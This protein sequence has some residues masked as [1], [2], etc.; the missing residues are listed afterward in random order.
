MITSPRPCRLV[1]SAG[2]AALLSGSVIGI[3][4]AD[5]QVVKANNTDNLNVGTSWIG[6]SVP[7]PA[8]IAAWDATVTGANSTLLGSDLTWGGITITN[9]GGLITI[10]GANRLTVA[11]AIGINLS[12]STQDLIIN[13]ALTVSGGTTL[14][15]RVLTLSGPN[16]VLTGIV[17][18]TATAG[19][20]ALNVTGGSLLL[21]GA[22][23]FSGQMGIGS[24]ATVTARNGS[25]L[26]A[27]GVGN[28]TV[29]LAGGTLNIGGQALGVERIRISGTGVGGV[30]AL[31][32][33]GAGNN[34]ATQF[35]S[36]IGNATVNAGGTLPAS[37]NASGG[38]LAG[39]VGR[40]DIRLASYT[41]NAANLNLAG[42]T[43]TKIGGGQFSLV[44][45][46]VTAGNIVV[47]E[48]VL[49][50]E[51]TT[52][53]NGAGTI[54]VNQGGKLAF[55]NL[56]NNGA[57]V[58]WPITVN[59]G[60][61][62]DVLSVTAAQTVAAPITIAGP[63]N[64]NFVAASGSLTTM[65]GVISKNA[66]S[67]ATEL[68]KRGAQV[69]AFSNTGNTFDL[70]VAIYQGTL[71]AIY[72][73]DLGAGG[74]PPNAAL[75]SSDNPLGTNPTIKLAGG[76]LS[77][78]I[79]MAN[80]ATLQ[81]WDLN[82]A[83]VIDLAPSGMDFD[84]RTNTAQTNKHV[85]ID[86][87]TFSPPNAANGY[88][89]GQNQFTFT[90]LNT[91]RLEIAQMT[92]ARDTHLVGGDQ[93]F[94][95]DILSPGKNSLTRSGGSTTQFIIPA[96]HEFNAYF[97][98]GGSTRVGSGFG[99]NTTDPNVKIGTGLITIGPGA[100]ITFLSSTNI[101]A[102]QPITLVSHRGS[103]A[104][105]NFEQFT[106]VPANLRA[107]GTG[108]LGLGGTAAFGDLDLS[109]LGDGTFRAGAGISGSGATGVINGQIGAGAGN[110]VRLGASG[111]LNVS[112]SNLITGDAVLEVGSPL[113][114]GTF[115]QQ[116]QGSQNG[117]VFLTETNNYTGGTIVNRSSTIR[118]QDNGAF[119][120]GPITAFGNLTAEGDFGT[121]INDAGTGHIPVSFYG[122]Y[123]VRF[124]SSLTST[125]V[126]VDRWLD[127]VPIPLLNATLQLDAR[128]SASTT[129][130]TV[131]AI[132]YAGGSTISL[133]RS[134]TPGAA[135]VVQLQTPSITRV[136]NGT[137]EITRSGNSGFGSTVRLLASTTAPTLTNN[138][139]NPS[140]ALIDATRLTTFATYDPSNGFLNAAYTNTVTTAG[141]PTGLTAG[142]EIVYVDFATGVLTSTLGDNPVVYALKVGAGQSAATAT[143][144]AAG[145]GTGITIRSGG[146]IISGDAST[147]N[148]S[149]AS[150]TQATINPSL[151]FNN[152]TSNI[153]ALINVRSATTGI[154]NGQIVANGLTKF[155]AG[156]L[157][158]TSNQPS[159]SGN[160]AI[161]QGIIQAFGSQTTG[162]TQN[163]LG[164]GLI[165]LTGG[166]LNL[167]TANFA[168]TTF[169][170]SNNGSYTM[171]N[172]FVIPENIP[173]GVVDVNRSTADTTSTGTITF[174]PT[175]PGSGLQLLGSAGAQ[176]QTITFSGANYGVV[177]DTNSLNSFA[178]NVTVNNAVNVTLQNN[179]TITGTNPVIT[180]S[181][182]GVLVVGTAISQPLEVTVVPGA[183]VVVNAGTLEMRNNLAFGSGGSTGTSLV[184]NGGALNLRSNFATTYGGDA[185]TPYAVT[186]NGN[187]TISTDRSDTAGA[188]NSA[189]ELDTL[190]IN[191]SPTVTFNNANGVYPSILGS[192]D[193]VSMRLNGLPFL[194]SNI[195]VGNL[196]SALRL[197]SA[198]VGGGFVKLGTGH[199]HLMDSNN[200]SGGTYIN[201]GVLRA[202]ATN[203]LGV[204]PVYLNPGAILDLNAI[205]N[206]RPDQPLMI[207]SNGA[208]IPML[209]V[210]T[211]FAHPTGPNV[212][213]SQA[214]NGIVGLSNG[215]GGIYSTVINLATMYG[216]QWSL[217]GVPSGVYDPIY[218]GETLGAGLDGLYRLGGGGTSFA[219]G[220]DEFRGAR[221]NVLTGPNN[222]RLGFDSGNLYP[223]NTTNFQFSIAG[224]NDYSGGSTV[225][226]RGMVARLFS[227]NDGA[228][229]G[230]SNSN[231]DV[232][233]IFGLSGSG[234]I[235]TGLANTNTVTL[236]PGSGLVLDSANG[237]ANSQ[238]SFAASNPGDRWNDTTPIA[239]NGAFLD[240]NGQRDA[241][242]T[243]IVGDVTYSRGARVR[244]GRSPV[245]VNNPGGGSSI[246]TMAN[247]FGTGPGNTL[248]LQTTLPGTLGG[249]DQILVTNNPPVVTNG[250]VSSSV[251]NVTDNTFVTYDVLNGFT[252]A[253]YDSI[254]PGGNIPTG[255]SA[256]TKLDLTTAAATLTDS[257]TVYALRTSQ[258]INIGGA[259]STINLRSGGL[260][261]T[262]GT[263][264]PNLVFND[265]AS[266][267]EGRIYVNG[268]LT[269]NGLI[270]ANG[271]TKFGHTGTAGG[272]AGTLVIN[273]P[274]PNYTSG[275]TVNSGALQIN[276]PQGLGQT[277][278]TNTITLN[279]SLSTTGQVNS[280][281]GG[282]NYAPTQLTLTYNSGTP[283]QVSFS[284]GPVTVVNE[285]TVRIAAG[286]DRNLQGLPVTLTSTSPASRVGFTMDVPNN[287]FRGTIPSLT[288]MNDAVIRVTDS[289]STA[290]TGR[291][292]AGVVT[293]LNG[294]GKNLTKIGNR[295]LELP[296][297][298][299]TTF[300]GGSVTVSQGTVRV[301]NN[302]SLG[303]P[304]TVTTIERNATLEIDTDAFTSAGPVNQ[305]PGSIERWN[306]EAARP[307]TTYNFPSGVNLQLNTN[308]LA[309][310]T[311]GLNGGSIEGFNWIDHPSAAVLRTVSSNV[312][313]N[314]LAD[315]FVG[316]NILQGQGYDAGRQPTVNSPFGEAVTGSFLQI[317]G[318][319]TGNFNL[320]KTGNDTVTI[321][322]ANT[323][324]NTFVEL[325]VLRTGSQNTLPS[326]GVVTTRLNGTLDLFGNN[327]TVS[328]LG[329]SATGA[330][331]GGTSVGSSGR[332]IN[333]APTDNILNVNTA[334]NFTYNGQ[335]EQNVALTKSGTGIL[336]LNAASG[337][338][339][340]TTV[341][342]GTLVVNAAL[343]GTSTIDVRSGAILDVSDVSSGFQLGSKQL[344]KGDGTIK[345]S[346]ATSGTVTPGSVG[347][348]ALTIDALTTLNTGSTL[349]LELNA[350]DT[351]DR[352]VTN[353]LIL[354][355]IVNLA[356]NLN[357]TPAVATQF[358]VVDNTGLNAVGGTTKLFTW[359]GPEGVLSEGEEFFVGA[360]LFSITYQGG[361][362]NDVV[363]VVVPEPSSLA[364]IAGAMGL[365]A[366]RRRRS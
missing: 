204:G 279:A 12:G 207:R 158:I 71:R 11:G 22:N 327:Q 65:S 231:V 101:G 178:G 247:L 121:F 359:N 349:Q 94:T 117:T 318:N 33:E 63:L 229:S 31:I 62:G 309:A 306:R 350:A 217:G 147:G 182:G 92:M 324:R 336:Q 69:L 85:I 230:F 59:G 172:S 260:I 363:L 366:L 319:I 97:G 216:G 18:G 273:V 44:A 274:Q 137:L 192:A 264:Q 337:Y 288:L 305:L 43:L 215:T 8:A 168:G 249:Q 42:N 251:V 51:S 145:A 220:T 159:L 362:G 331:P 342:A 234:S 317:D 122:G 155:G 283:E 358:L 332:I 100:G 70:P 124:N 153:E 330:D 295:T 316:Q 210:N 237:A 13:S 276:D 129:N 99:T 113:I 128:N 315:S 15:S 206:L 112:G 4:K 292:T 345:G 222:V 241:F 9:P 28:E 66:A 329:V 239:L 32:N 267:V 125:D 203:A 143:T 284:G 48:G 3:P 165:R 169:S 228:R 163:A 199:L 218:T 184:L 29:V 246:L 161:N 123:T 107:A 269:L 300:S 212:D 1:L 146:L 119:G 64:P 166:Q 225:I 310:R 313:I 351:F 187:S 346:I 115:T 38:L 109:R 133:Q 114:N 84:R 49:S 16:S 293:Q 45:A 136:G 164:T 19:T 335:I 102:N 348:G 289:G 140:I 41:T 126:D 111:T 75:T 312:T 6:G 255:L 275:W 314:L 257:L 198:V 311:I 110:I 95:G 356:I 193:G 98:L 156:T 135:Q 56:A 266:N 364:V 262:G 202:R 54:T 320:T 89:I 287:R 347:P 191:G 242:T 254:V 154:L 174:S 79:N 20:A 61:I 10:G 127:S 176:G 23:T 80:D 357:F 68:A 150:G 26:G 286:D 238:N 175:V 270:T 280:S 37:F 93:T 221:V 322:G 160:V 223:I 76:T 177:F 272:A 118:F 144:L 285:G 30:G 338:R 183:Q 2:I 27:S 83:I 365:L 201:Q 50:I 323:Y 304:T 328:G 34:N 297:D 355:G 253:T 139:V 200:Y 72:N 281:A 105:A 209:S 302:G 134:N 148:F 167:R 142:T 87:L 180:K 259:S 39:G 208:F 131:G 5:A 353:G 67:T 219:M 130:E 25:A 250:M 88:S 343:S 211:D 294:L 186:I 333:S 233:G 301:R 170:T 120:T 14:G 103:M 73:T 291:I 190:T 77:L 361:T 171:Q 282:T 213:A 108:V 96:T 179:P 104:A 307:G 188:S 339:G 149:N 360:Q 341:A 141:F 344:L 74:V 157:N 277:V 36:L 185:S 303:S 151:T 55:W 248:A 265:G 224:V 52:V 24:G 35:V 181:G 244:A 354:D 53:L 263:I 189:Q 235:S 308:L 116:V 78:R 197:N 91:H 299:S 290:D 57:N 340:A 252:N 258:N 245:D 227:F 132:S 326:S 86:S 194:A 261:G 205:D 321:A 196:N 162:A 236:H 138:M 325:G 271:V 7:G 47:N 268:T 21:S 60:T 232:F 17:S 152:G 240:L 243:E 214:P 352:L 82:K 298:N 195:G 90:Q 173:L 226:H 46:D 296:N 58:A 334:G 106:E 40:F 256:T 278:P 81:S